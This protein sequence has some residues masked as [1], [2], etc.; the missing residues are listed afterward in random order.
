[1]KGEKM[2]QPKLLEVEKEDECLKTK[3]CPDCDASL[4]VYKKLIIP[5]NLWLIHYE[6]L[7]CGFKKKEWE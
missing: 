6:C 3:K 7:D 4:N 2:A 1:M 5:A